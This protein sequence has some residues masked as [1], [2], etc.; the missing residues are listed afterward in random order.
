MFNNIFTIYGR[1]IGG[2]QRFY[3]KRS[4][5]QNF[6]NELTSLFLIILHFNLPLKTIIKEIELLKTIILIFSMVFIKLP[7][8]VSGLDFY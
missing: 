4:F 8:L 7:Y 2:K 5:K 3:V 6:K 1:N